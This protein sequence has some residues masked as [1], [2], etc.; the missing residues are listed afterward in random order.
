[1]RPRSPIAAAAR[2]SAPA[3]DIYAA[4]E[5]GEIE[6]VTEILSTQPELLN[7]KNQQGLTVVHLAARR[8]HSELVEMLLNRGADLEEPDGE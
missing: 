1:M 4:A 7:A 6:R 2:S 5:A 8:G 3:Q